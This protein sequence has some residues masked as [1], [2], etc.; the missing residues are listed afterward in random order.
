M[1]I[2]MTIEIERMSL[3]AYHGVMEQERRVGNTFEVSVALT[4]NVAE[5]VTDQ[6][7]NT[8][9]Y[10]VITDIIKQQMSI[11]SKLLEH[12]ASRIRTAILNRYPQVVTGY[13]K[14]IKTTPPLGI[15]LHSAS[16]KL[17]WG[18]RG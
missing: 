10:A 18:T 11:P 2:R 9:N 7:D 4:Y 16:A 14:V 3:F 12:V 17:E 13:V 8:V 5:P 6:L 15:K 1:S